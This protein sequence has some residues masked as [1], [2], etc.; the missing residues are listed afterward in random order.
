M[1][2]KSF[3]KRL[4]RIQ[5]QPS[6]V[7]TSELVDSILGDKPAGGLR[8]AEVSLFG[9]IFGILVG[10]GT[11]GFLV[12]EGLWSPEMG[13]IG[14]LFGI[15]VLLVVLASPVLAVI[16]AITYKRRPKLMRFASMNLL[17]IVAVLL[18]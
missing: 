8:G 16:G 9:A 10:V 3:D 5:W 1:T 7:P 6:A 12:Q 18:S 4:D 17:M 2:T 13:Q 11:K 15:L 14:V